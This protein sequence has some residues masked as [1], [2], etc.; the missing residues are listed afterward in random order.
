MKRKEKVEPKTTGIGSLMFYHID[1][2]ASHTANSVNI[3]S[4]YNKSFL[5]D[6]FPAIHVKVATINTATTQVFCFKILTN[7]LFWPT[8]N[9]KILHFLCVNTICLLRKRKN[10]RKSTTIQP[11]AV[12]FVQNFNLFL[13]LCCFVELYKRTIKSIQI[14]V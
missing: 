8:D 6:F 2:Y 3:S 12:F 11:I 7:N 9:S 1:F 10:D 5:V 13:F 4:K 14:Y